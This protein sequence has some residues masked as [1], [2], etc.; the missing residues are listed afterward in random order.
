MISDADKDGDGVKNK[1]N[2]KVKRRGEKGQI[3]YLVRVDF[4]TAAWKGTRRGYL[5]IIQFHLLKQ[6]IIKPKKRTAR[7]GWVSKAEF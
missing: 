3:N 7:R 1:I 5:V 6:S 2:I 4:K